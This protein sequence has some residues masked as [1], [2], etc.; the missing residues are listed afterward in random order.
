MS[1][2]LQWDGAIS[3]PLFTANHPLSWNVTRAGVRTPEVPWLHVGVSA[4]LCCS[5]KK[6]PQRRHLR[7]NPAMSQIFIG[8]ELLMGAS[9]EIWTQ[10]RPRF[11]QRKEYG[12]GGC[13]GCAAGWCPH[14]RAKLQKRN[15]VCY[16][17]TTAVYH[18]IQEPPS[19]PSK[20][21][22]LINQL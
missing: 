12:K 15:I 5:L 8:A 10:C 21:S 14:A 20:I 18:Q 4:L 17:V 22:C 13:R 19:R 3:C 6:N 16:S 11:N 2:C 9:T 7:D 1:Q